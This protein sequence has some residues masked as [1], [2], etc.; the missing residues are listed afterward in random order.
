[1]MQNPRVFLWIALGLV[2]WL[3]YEAWQRDYAPANQAIKSSQTANKA[4]GPAATEPRD[5]GA[6][7]PQPASA[8][9]PSSRASKARTSSVGAEPSATAYPENIGPG[10]IHIRTDVLDLDISK[11]GGTIQRADLLRYPKVK[12]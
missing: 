7:I 3:N 4:T 10:V 8:P 1:M 5:L 12:G 11:R 6:V 2:L 9:A